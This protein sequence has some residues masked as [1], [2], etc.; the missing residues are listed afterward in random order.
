MVDWTLERDDDGLWRWMHL[1]NKSVTRSRRRFS[2][3]W[4]CVEDARKHGLEERG[5]TESPAPALLH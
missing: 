4:E 2:H 5:Q 3:L 1:E